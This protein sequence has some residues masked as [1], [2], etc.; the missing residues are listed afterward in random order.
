MVPNGNF[1]QIKLVGVN[2][3]VIKPIIEPKDEKIDKT[4]GKKKEE[5][6]KA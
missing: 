2:N 1:E 6:L 3:I 4:V 5:I